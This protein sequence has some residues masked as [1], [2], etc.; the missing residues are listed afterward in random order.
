MMAL[1]RLS[2]RRR[3]SLVKQAIEAGVEYFF[4]VDPA[5]AHFPGE[6]A[7]QPNP[8]WWQFHFPLFWVTDILQVT[9]VL[10]ALGYGNDPRLAN[11][12]MLVHKKQD[13]NGRW[14]LEID[15]YRNRMWQNY[16]VKGKPNKW[17]TLRA[18]RVLKQAAKQ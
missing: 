2:A 6:K 15:V 3:T 16:G 5:T 9:E 10:T 13:E 8:G 1:S 4:S 14:P 12:L 7:P 17:V 11:T 18:M